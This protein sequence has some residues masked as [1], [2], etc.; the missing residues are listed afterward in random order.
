VCSALTLLIICSAPKGTLTATTPGNDTTASI[1][2]H[3]FSRPDQAEVK[4]LEL[5]LTVDFKKKQLSGK[6]TLFIVNKTGTDKLFLD[7]RDLII[8]KVTIGKKGMDTNFS[9]GEQVQYLGRQLAV[10]IL[11]DTKQVNVYYSTSPSAAAL[12]WLEPTQTASGKPFLFTQSEAILA[13]SWVPC[14]DNPSVRVTYRATIKTPPAMLAL[15]SAQ[16]T[17]KKDPKGKYEFY[18][19]QP[20]PSYLLALAV[21]DID[22]RAISE[23]CGVYAEPSVVDT[24][25][26]EF[27]DAE[28][29]I[30]TAEKLYGPYR[31]GRYDI[32]VLPPSFPYGGM[33]NPRLTFATPTLLAGDRSLVSTVAHELAHSWSGNLVT[34]ATWDDFWLNEGFTIYYERRIDEALYGRE[35]SEMEPLLGLESLRTAITEMGP[36]SAYTK[37]HLNLVGRDPDDGSSDIAYEKGYLFLRQIEETVGRERWDSFLRKYFDTFA[38]QSMTTPRFIAYL[39]ENL[40]MGDRLLE[41]KLH[42]DTWTDST[43]LPA[44]PSTIHSQAFVRVEAQLKLW[45]EGTPAKNLNTVGWVNQQWQYFIRNLRT[46]STLDRVA[47][48]D[49]AFHFTQ[50][51]NGELLPHWFVCAI[52]NGYVQA[53]PRIEQF[54]LHI[55]RRRLVQPVYAELAKTQEGLG[56]ARRIYAKARPRYHELTV[57]SIDEVLHWQK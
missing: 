35:F 54:L 32:I 24:A 53:Y 39:R 10:D 56:W 7:T 26:W 2:N 22:F 38:F 41:E 37:L 31:W 5:D 45:R 57:N 13:R 34:N 8:S 16:N 11:P 27:A 33:E 23:R 28:K 4:H 1:Q 20:I 47:E 29:M 21:G 12:Q 46:P 42:I 14:Q 52:R 50:S 43:G 48:L 36:D 51:G 18:M 55:G 17:T 9:L 49:E 40:V 19:P 30:A 15:M 6:A 25:A 44:S 3:S